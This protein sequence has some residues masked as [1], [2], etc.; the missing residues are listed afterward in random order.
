[1][2]KRIRELYYN[3][4]ILKFGEDDL[5][6][7]NVSLQDFIDWYSTYKKVYTSSK[8]IINILKDLNSPLVEPFSEYVKN[9]NDTSFYKNCVK[10]GYTDT[11][12]ILNNDLQKL[13]DKDIEKISF[14]DA[15]LFC[16]NSQDNYLIVNNRIIILKLLNCKHIEKLNDLKNAR[17][18]RVQ[19]LRNIAN[20]LKLRIKFVKEIDVHMEGLDLLEKKDVGVIIQLVKQYTYKKKIMKVVEYVIKDVK[21]I[22]KIKKYLSYE[23]TTYNKVDFFFLNRKDHSL[24]DIFNKIME[25]HEEGLHKTSAYVKD[26]ITDYKLR[27]VNFLEYIDIFVSNEI[28]LKTEGNKDPIL[29]FFHTCTESQIYELLLNYG[30]LSSYD[31]TKVKSKNSKHHQA[32][33][34]LTI[35][36]MFLKKLDT[37]CT[38]CSTYIKSLKISLFLNQIENKSELL[39]WDKRR[40]YTDEEVDNMVKIADTTKDKLMITILREIGLRNSAI[41]NL[42]FKDIIDINRIPKHAC[43]VKEKGNKIREFVT[44]DKIKQYIVSYVHEVEQTGILFD[45]KNKENMTKFVFS[46]NKNLDVKMGSA[47]LNNVLK[48]LGLKAGITNVN[49]QSHTFRH[50]L[51]G[52]LMDAGNN[53]EVVSKFIG[54]SSVDTTMNYYWLKNIT[55]LA[56]E[57]NNPFT[58][59][60]ITPEEKREEDNFEIDLL[61]KKI[62]TCF[63]IIGI[64]KNQISE[65]KTI[66]E[67]KNTVSSND[68]Y[69]NKILKY[70]ADSE[71]G[72]TTSIRSQRTQWLNAM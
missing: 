19:Y 4:M 55:E 31:N 25:E 36:V 52:K 7:N 45:E 2:N 17:L 3:P 70:I 26:R 15:L 5:K 22:E 32:R 12:K 49:I 35:A 68:V 64:Y 72:D 47:T 18:E 56:N 65:A 34:R 14:E 21:K 23:Y 39:D 20:N 33:H 54:H 48:R 53:I 40:V 28:K 60:M 8:T 38:H 59:T 51:V 58:Q 63:Q 24:F 6:N 57:I 30:S 44:S 50:T 67:L 27:I 29:N 16:T 41:C 69:I 42:K 61:N 71:A 10:L 66:E 46:R 11:N 13:T 43:R 1:M 62:D 37:I 9:N